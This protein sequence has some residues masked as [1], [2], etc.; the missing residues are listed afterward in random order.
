MAVSSQARGAHPAPKPSETGSA[1]LLRLPR[2]TTAG[3]PVRSTLRGGGGPGGLLCGPAGG[4][5]TA[6]G[7]RGVTVHARRGVAQ[8]GGTLGLAEPQR[9][10]DRGRLLRDRLLPGP[11]AASRLTALLLLLAALLLPTLLTG[12]SGLGRS[13]LGSAAVALLSGA[14]GVGAVSTRSRHER[15]GHLGGLLLRLLHLQVEQI[16]DHLV[17]DRL[18]HRLE[19]L[20]ALP[21]VLHQ[22]VALGHGP[23]P[24]ALLEIVHLIEVLAPL[25][26]QHREHHPALELTHDL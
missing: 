26:V 22:R 14:P 23:Q 7:R 8:R 3:L 15:L 1:A 5:G 10:V 19:Q 16:A 6:C 21:L 25:A 12:S 18:V 9:V 2:S 17:L 11:A 20:V 13:S 24:D 4:C